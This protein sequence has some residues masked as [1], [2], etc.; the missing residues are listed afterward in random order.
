MKTG[1]IDK[2]GKEVETG[3]LVKVFEISIA[4][5]DRQ[6]EIRGADVVQSDF[7]GIVA[8]DD[9]GQDFELRNSAGE[10]IIG[11][12]R[13]QQTYEI[14]GRELIAHPTRKLGEDRS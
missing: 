1:L 7:Y 3:D 8:W 10:C 11:I 2:H 9:E 12:P 13:H 5:T 4:Q 14:V 6:R